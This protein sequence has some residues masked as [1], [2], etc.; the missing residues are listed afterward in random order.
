MKKKFYF[1]KTIVFNTLTVLVVVATFFG[2]VPDQAIAET[3][4]AIL[5]ALTPL[6]NIGLRAVTNKGIT[7]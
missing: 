3:T 1:S 4:S 6:I 5:L 7:I 2:Y